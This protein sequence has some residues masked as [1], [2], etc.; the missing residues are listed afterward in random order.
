MLRNLFK[1]WLKGAEPRL[2]PELELFAGRGGVGQLMYGQIY[3]PGTA[4]FGMFRHLK[5]VK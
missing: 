3:I 1:A 2:L 5:Y 4:G